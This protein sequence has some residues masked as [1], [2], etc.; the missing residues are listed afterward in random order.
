[1][2]S[3]L[4]QK[5]AIGGMPDRAA[6]PMRKVQNVTG[7]GFLSPPIWLML[8]VCMAWITE[9]A[10]RNSNALNH[11]CVK[12]WNSPGVYPSR[13]NESPATMYAS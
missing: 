10:A 13:P 2:I 11:A 3:S 7:R 1:M 4:D 9:P 8:F 12:R 6:A 5:P